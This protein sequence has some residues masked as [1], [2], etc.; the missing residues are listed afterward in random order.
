MEI[1]NRVKIRTYKDNEEK[2]IFWDKRFEGLEGEITN[3][4]GA[5]FRVFF[6]NP[7]MQ[8]SWASET[9]KSGAFWKD[10]LILLEEVKTCS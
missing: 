3:I 8:D 6:D 7:P 1:G 2:P 4:E 9:W 10:E 5:Q